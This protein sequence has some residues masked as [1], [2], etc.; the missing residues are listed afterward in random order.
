M[1]NL[2]EI[3]AIIAANRAAGRDTYAGLDS[4]EVGAFNRA[5]MFG[6]NDEAFPGDA[7]WSRIVD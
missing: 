4:S 3:R 5:L 1:K 7:E 6:D 2:A